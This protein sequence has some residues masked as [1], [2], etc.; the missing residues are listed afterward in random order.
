M[1]IFFSTSLQK[2][3]TSKIQLLQLLLVRTVTKNKNES[4][5]ESIMMHM[6]SHAYVNIC[7][8]RLKYAANVVRACVTSRKCNWNTEQNACYEQKS[9]HITKNKISDIYT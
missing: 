2:E 4:D 5:T 3:N 9:K 7:E 6:K 8:I 1:S